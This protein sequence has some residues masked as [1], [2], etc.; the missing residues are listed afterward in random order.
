MLPHAPRNTVKAE[1][2]PR[3]TTVRALRDLIIASPRTK[4]VDRTRPPAKRKTAVGATTSSY[5]RRRSDMVSDEHP[6]SVSPRA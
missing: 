6:I 1:A 5:L 2:I 3:L 4:I